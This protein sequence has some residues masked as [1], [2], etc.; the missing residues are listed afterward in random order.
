[1]QNEII[2]PSDS[3]TDANG[4]NVRPVK[5]ESTETLHRNSKVATLKAKLATQSKLVAEQGM[6][7]NKLRKENKQ[8]KNERDIQNA[9]ITGLQDELKNILRQL[10]DET[11]KNLNF[12]M[13]KLNSLKSDA[14]N[15]TAVE[16]T[17]HQD[18]DQ[19]MSD[20]LASNLPVPENGPPN[21]ASLQPQI[22]NASGSSFTAIKPEPEG[23][24]I[25]VV[26]KSELEHEPDLNVHVTF[27]KSEDGKFD[28]WNLEHLRLGPPVIVER[29]FHVG[30][31]RPVISN[32]LGGNW[33]STFVNWQ[34]P[35][36]ELNRYPYMALKR[37]WNPH[38]PLVPG[39]HGVVFT[40]VRRFEDDTLI[41]G[42]VDVVISGKPN[43]WVYFGSYETFRSGEIT[44]HQLHLLPPLVV[45][46]WVE[47]TLK[48]QWGKN[49]VERTN[50]ELVDKGGEIR[51]VEHT[52]HGLREALSD[53]RLVIGFTV[54]KCVGFRTDWFDQFLHYQAHPKLRTTQKRKKGSS[55]AKKPSAKRVKGGTHRKEVSS[56]SD[57]DE[58]L[59]V[60]PP[61][62]DGDE[63]PDAEDGMKSRLGSASLGERKSARISAKSVG[64]ATPSSSHRTVLSRT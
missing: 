47:G 60:T 3:D 37:S 54:M 8:F 57:S 35:T 43:E 16:A 38:L 46:T 11:V 5:K 52:A 24:K 13:I 42:S 50:A 44:P 61:G 33:Q 36:S 51:L 20:S 41:T 7:L 29:R 59:Q 9:E 34:G 40:R 23:A 6:E 49:W 26:I 17:W 48:S 62:S 55:G 2:E 56:E 18:I 31:R 19:D 25:A 15:G 58:K 53:G 12:N 28:I 32:A 63:F 21:T 64:A 27:V 30:F 22:P 1:M 39:E 14:P 10:D 45:R 4:K